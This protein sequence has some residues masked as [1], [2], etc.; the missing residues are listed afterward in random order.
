MI[1]TQGLTI[2]IE[3]IGTQVLIRLKMMGKLTHEDYALMTPLIDDALEGIGKRQVK[4][5]ADLRDL[6]GF[7]ARAVWDDF[8]LGLKHHHQ[9]KQVAVIGEQNWLGFATRIGNVLTGADIK[10]FDNEAEA[11]SWLE[12]D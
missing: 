9:F 5:L 2:G 1:K 7:E 4:A 8:K 11:I 10:S 3:R 6:E 12:N